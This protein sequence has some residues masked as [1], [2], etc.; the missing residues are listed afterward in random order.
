[1]ERQLLFLFNYEMRFSEADA[2]ASW[3]PLMRGMYTDDRA[4]ASAISKV[5][6]AGKARAEARQQMQVPPTPS[7]DTEST[8]SSLASTVRNLAKRISMVQISSNASSG[9]QD[10]PSLPPMNR[11]Y[12]TASGAASRSS[13]DI[14]EL[15]DDNGSTSG[16]SSGW[17]SDSDVEEVHEPRIY[18]EQSHYGR[19]RISDEDQT[20]RDN[21]TRKPF[22]LR[23]ASSRAQLRVQDRSRKPSDSSS[24]C[25]ITGHDS[26]LRSTSSSSRPSDFS[27]LEA[28]PST[29]HSESSANWGTSSS[30]LLSASVTLPSVVRASHN[31]VSTAGGFLS[32]MWGAAKTQALAPADRAITSSVEVDGPFR[33]L[34]RL[35]GS[36]LS[37]TT[38]LDV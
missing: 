34:T 23:L 21:I 7:S 31:G 14:E 17:T 12:R 36:T 33:K 22:M 18:R 38:L 24:V 26:S 25:T 3:A 10:L 27:S 1:M 15:T 11:P 9:R 19:P 30:S 37:G 4:R 8:V 13:S 20:L 5:A 6:K 16:S 32:R 29:L 35:R 2:I 28:R